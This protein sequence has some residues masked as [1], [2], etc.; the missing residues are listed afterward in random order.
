MYSLIWIFDDRSWI[1]A[2]PSLDDLNHLSDVNQR[3]MFGIVISLTIPSRVIVQ[4]VLHH[5]VRSVVRVGMRCVPTVVKNIALDLV[6]FA[7]MNLHVVGSVEERGRHIYAGETLLFGGE[8]RWRVEER[9][10]DE[11]FIS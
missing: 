5:D 10:E 4:D 9:E 1:A 8:E 2:R 3:D 7:A 6:E 11:G